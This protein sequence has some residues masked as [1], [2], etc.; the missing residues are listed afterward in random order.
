[1][2]RPPELDDSSVPGDLGRRVHVHACVNKTQVLGTAMCVCVCACACVTRTA[3]LCVCRVPRAKPRRRLVAAQEPLSK[4]SS[5]VKAPSFR[6][7]GSAG[8]ACAPQLPGRC[9]VYRVEGATIL[10]GAGL[11]AT[12]AHQGCTIRHMTGT[13]WR[14]SYGSYGAHAGFI[15]WGNPLEMTV[16]R[17]DH[18]AYDATLVRNP[19][20][21]VDTAPHKTQAHTPMPTPTHAASPES[22]CCQRS[23]G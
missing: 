15:R 10:A 8:P 19:P 13:V 12:R 4:T 23:C 2:G 20:R 9:G 14:M 7:R 16:D 1:V 21:S 17:M 22:A 3:C 11:P 18:M 5:G 6:S